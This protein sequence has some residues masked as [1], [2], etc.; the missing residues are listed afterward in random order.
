MTYEV[1]GFL[2]VYFCLCSIY[3][4]TL[5]HKVDASSVSM[6]NI[7]TQSWP[8]I[9]TVSSM[10][11]RIIEEFLC[12]EL[13]LSQIHGEKQVCHFQKLPG[14]QCLIKLQGE[15]LPKSRFPSPSLIPMQSHA[16]PLKIQKNPYMNH[17]NHETL[18]LG[19]SFLHVS[20]HFAV[21]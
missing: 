9:K 12:L 19:H 13:H 8:S 1:S 6:K 7:F 5:L 4:R 3:P 15:A 21:Y 18:T 16:Q 14:K 20:R 10:T 11:N 17:E 2:E